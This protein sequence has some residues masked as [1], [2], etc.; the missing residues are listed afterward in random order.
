MFKGAFII[1]PSVLLVGCVNYGQEDRYRDDW[2]RYDYNRPDPAY[3]NYYADRYHRDDPRYRERRLSRNERIYR[4]Q[5]GRYYCR[6]PDGTTGLIVGAIAGGVLG[7]LI[8]PGG[9]EELG[10]IL[11]AI[12][13]GFAGREIER[14]QDV[15]CR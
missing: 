14:D 4:G 3:G 15:R 7:N 8:A 10:T 5:D 9:S 6:R 13:G 2:S 11:G 12:G 1:L